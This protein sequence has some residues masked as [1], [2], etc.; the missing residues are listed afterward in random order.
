M[1]GIFSLMHAYLLLDDSRCIPY[2]IHEVYQLLGVATSYP[3]VVHRLSLASEMIGKDV[4]REHLLLIFDCL[5]YTNNIFSYYLVGYHDF[6]HCMKFVVPFTERT[7]K[8]PIREIEKGV[9]DSIYETQHHQ[10]L[11]A[12]PPDIDG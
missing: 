6:Y 1:H 3:L 5:N 2:S 12:T 7:L 8:T 9:K 10:T 11:R 4:F